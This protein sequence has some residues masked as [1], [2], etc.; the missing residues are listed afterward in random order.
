MPDRCGADIV[1]TTDFTIRRGSRMGDHAPPVTVQ[2]C[3]SS[4]E[5]VTHGEGGG[6]GTIAHLQLLQN[7][8]DVRLCGA[9][10]DE[11]RACDLIIR[12]SQDEEAEYFGFAG[13]ETEGSVMLRRTP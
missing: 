10:S 12:P 9:A 8:G 7:A 11:E 4:A 2:R 5:L 3:E 13:G 1:R 6:L